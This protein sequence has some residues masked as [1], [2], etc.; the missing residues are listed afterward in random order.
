LCRDEK[1]GTIIDAA[2]KAPEK[3]HFLTR[4]WGFFANEVA[5]GRKYCKK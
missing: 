1:F 3:A 4:F 2:K 5:F